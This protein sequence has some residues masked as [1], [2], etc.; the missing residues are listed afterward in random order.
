MGL[1]LA[2]YCGLTLTL[3]PAHIRLTAAV[4][5]KENKRE[6][7]CWQRSKSKYSTPSICI[8][9]CSNTSHLSR[10]AHLGIHRRTIIQTRGSTETTE[11]H[12][13]LSMSVELRP[14][15]ESLDPKQQTV[16]SNRS[17]IVSSYRDS[18][19]ILKGYIDNPRTPFWKRDICASF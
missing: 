7:A 6:F 2:V 5:H 9:Y 18:G 11:A 19:G 14:L 12:V 1:G 16:A 3:E 15:P 10:P 4:W 17:K 8:S 13:L